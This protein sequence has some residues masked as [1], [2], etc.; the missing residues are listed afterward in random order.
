MYYKPTSPICRRVV[1]LHL[2]MLSSWSVAE[3]WLEAR[4][5]GLLLSD[6]RVRVRGAERRPGAGSQQAPFSMA[7]PF[8]LFQDPAP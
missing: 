7:S 5:L 1:T 3:K 4:G 6:S 2:R 8:S